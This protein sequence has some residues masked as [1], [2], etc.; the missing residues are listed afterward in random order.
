LFWYTYSGYVGGFAYF[1]KFKYYGYFKPHG[2]YRGKW[3]DV[4]MVFITYRCWGQ[5]YRN[6]G[7]H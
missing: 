5:L 1:S 7:C 2:Y 4:S 3:H 6:I